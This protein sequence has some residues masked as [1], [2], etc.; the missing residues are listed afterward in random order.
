MAC[1]QKLASV[2]ANV[3]NH[4]NSERHLD[5]RTTF[6]QRRS[7]ALAERRLGVLST[8]TKCGTRFRSRSISSG[9][10]LGA[11]SLF[12]FPLNFVRSINLCF[13]GADCH[14]FPSQSRAEATIPNVRE[15]GG[16]CLSTALCRS[17]DIRLQQCHRDPGKLGR[18]SGGAT[19]TL[20]RLLTTV[21]S[22]FASTLVRS[23]PEADISG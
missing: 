10:G 7:A 20:R 16:L 4:F 1:L 6:K 23:P 19:S 21:A 22:C 13:V 9:I 11:A 2:H 8:S 5:D 15:R 12:R 3:H 14:A 18:T 17:V